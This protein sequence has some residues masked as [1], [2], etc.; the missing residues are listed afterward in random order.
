MSTVIGVRDHFSRRVSFN[1]LNPEYIENEV[2]PEKINFKDPTFG[3]GSNLVSN[4]IPK[5]FGNV[6][7]PFKK[8][9]KLPDPPSKSILKNKYT[10]QDV[11]NIPD[12]SA[13]EMSDSDSDEDPLLSK[14]ADK[15]QAQ[16]RRKSYSEMTDE[17]LME[18]DPQYK[19]T[20]PKSTDLGS[21]K[22]DS[23]TTYYL[24]AA[25]RSST[26][27]ALLKQGYPSSNENNYKSISLTVKH[28]DYDR[29]YLKRTLLTIISGRK[30]TWSSLDWLLNVDKIK[31]KI[32]FL[33]DGDYLIVASLIP[34][35]FIKE[36]QSKKKNFAEFLYKKCQN[37][38]NYI[39]ELLPAD[40]KMK[41][42]IEFVTDRAEQHGLS[43]KHAISGN[44][45]MLSHLYKQY[46]PTLLILGNK[47]TNINFKY[48][49]K[50]SSSG[51]K[52]EYLLKLSSYVIK[53]SSIPVICVG[54]TLVSKSQVDKAPATISFAGE[55]EQ[56]L[57]KDSVCSIDSVESFTG[58][59]SPISSKLDQML[60]SRSEDRF[61]N[62]MIEISDNS[63]N[64]ANQY[65]TAINSKTDNIRINEKV[66]NMYKSQTN[67]S[68]KSNNKQNPASIYKVKS[69]IS[70][71]EE[72]EDKNEKMRKEKRRSSVHQK[73]AKEAP[74]IQKKQSFWKKLS[75]KK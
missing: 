21:F 17:E 15:V 27:T 69:M 43:E 67:S 57:R 40:L 9:K 61:K 2:E 3:Y 14:L 32:S 28:E 7:T 44:K 11:A 55:I 41:I 73:E 23:Q 16:P 18:L 4:D 30:H 34:N 47:S 62:M 1:N 50:M 63:L 36:Y 22:F 33:Q 42:T 12:S 71:N 75:F 45:Y 66:H 13:I 46:Q 70:Y 51:D 19:M 6:A 20:K 26:T 25:R 64:D 49:V 52:K 35:L 72:E 74:T 59:E 65:L 39:I 37:L 38:L 48:P 58:E 31:N 8:R 29:I 60:F 54:N 56:T 10:L 24:P 68:C 5:L 53:Y